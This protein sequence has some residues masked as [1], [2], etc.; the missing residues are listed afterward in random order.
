VP[1]DAEILSVTIDGRSEP[2]R[3]AN[4]ELSLP[5][6]PGEHEVN[7]RWR[8]DLP[9]GV[10]AKTP[11]VDLGAAAGNIE[12]ALEL[13]QSRWILLTRGPQL[14][15]AVMYWSELAMLLVAA[16]ILGRIPLTPL[17]TRH[18]L[19]LGLG[20]STFSW[21]ALA[22]VAG[23]LLVAGAKS[24]WPGSPSWWRFNLVQLFV[25]AM[26]IA[27]LAAIVVTVPAGL[28][29]LPDMHI[30]GNGSWGNSLKW[31]A[32]R[33]ASALPM[34]SVLTLPLWV[35]KLL[36]LAWALWLSFALLRWLPWVWSC[37]VSQGLWRAR[38]YR[39]AGN[40]P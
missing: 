15:P 22:I 39:E 13:P 12:L 1:D 25:A 33:S 14:G 7:V 26:T 30:A 3:A 27:A 24:R 32:D 28:L 36:V 11:G 6:L 29:G 23:W 18:W 38:G 10:V 2:L 35:Y 16:L 31:F 21:A 37:L 34:A 9:L 4:G 5:I 40:L 20:F 17:R 19:L 8:Q